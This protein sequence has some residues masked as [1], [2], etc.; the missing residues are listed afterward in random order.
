ME[1]DNRIKRIDAELVRLGLDLYL[2]TNTSDIRWITGFP[3]V[4]D[5]EQAHAMLIVS[6]SLA[7]Q[8]RRLLHTDMRYSGAMRPLSGGVLDVLDEERRSHSAF[9]VDQLRALSA[10]EPGFQRGIR[11]GIESDLPLSSFRNLDKTLAEADIGSY[12]L[13]ETDSFILQLRAVKDASEIADIKAAQAITDAAF[14]HMLDYLRS[15]LTEAEAAVELDFFMRKAGAPGL[16]FSSILASAERAALPH[17][18]PG[19][20]LLEPGDFVL[21]DFGARVNDYCSDMTRTVVLGQASQRQREIYET[22]LAAQLAALDMIRPGLPAAD[23]QL[24]VNRIFAERGFEPLSHGLGHGVGIDIHEQPV[25]SAS[26]EGELAVGHVVTVEP[27][28][29]LEGFGG[30]RIE[31]FG[32]VTADG[33]DDFTASAKQLIEL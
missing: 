5:S 9:V 26:A 6:T 15:G 11:I 19:G 20:R 13:V 25:M 18:V 4:F 10:G 29:Y 33:F 1:T 32:V 7:S 12:E 30:V 27:G 24:E 8:P 2:A 16:A 31:D 22:V 23:A 3:N 28:I 21:M 17:A 14:L